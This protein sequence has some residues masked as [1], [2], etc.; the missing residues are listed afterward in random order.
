M[1]QVRKASKKQAR[2]KQLWRDYC[3]SHDMT[4]KGGFPVTVWF[5]IG[6]AEPDVGIMSEY[7]YDWCVTTRDGCNC[8]WLNLTEKQ[9]QDMLEE[10]Y[11]LDPTR[12]DYDYDDY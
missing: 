6:S 5:T 7:I 10:I 9:E 11:E 12:D 8:E 1:K 3:Y 4:V 2:L